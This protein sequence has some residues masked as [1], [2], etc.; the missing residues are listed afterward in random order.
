MIINLMNST[1]YR[2][3]IEWSNFWYDNANLKK[4]SSKRYLLIGDSTVRMVR[5]TFAKITKCS[6]DM[7]GTSSALDDVLFVNQLEAFFSNI[8]YKY[9]AIFVQLGHHGRISH[10][11]GD[12]Q[13][14]DFAKYK[15]DF[16]KLIDFLKQYSDTIIV[17]TIFDSVISKP[18]LMNLLMK[19]LNIIKEVE[20]D[21][22]N[23]CTKR[24]NQILLSLNEDQ[25]LF[26]GV[27]ILD[28]NNLAKEKHFYR[29]DHIHFESK[30]KKYIA[31]EM[32][33]CLWGQ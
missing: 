21:K 14:V 17:E 29:I 32:A 7:L 6:V 31:Q 10:H 26:D 11:G 9:D 22:I 5:S 4:R 8:I 13:D 19:K 12:Y 28:I 25:D 30:A 2:E 15:E 27:K 3:S 23:K 33:K 24:K 18:G 20:D 16:L 1:D